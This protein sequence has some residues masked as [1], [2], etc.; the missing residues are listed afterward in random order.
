[1]TSFPGAEICLTFFFFLDTV[2]LVQVS[3]TS[4]TLHTPPDPYFPSLIFF[5]QFPPL[6][7]YKTQPLPF[8]FPPKPLSSPRSTPRRLEKRKIQHLRP[9]IHLTLLLKM[10]FLKYV[11]SFPF[12]LLLPPLYSVISS[13]D[14]SPLYIKLTQMIYLFQKSDRGFFLFF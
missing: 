8:P 1:M 13:L 5:F 2:T 4:A 6:L 11:S 3:I 9:H 7:Q 14:L 10:N 12:Y